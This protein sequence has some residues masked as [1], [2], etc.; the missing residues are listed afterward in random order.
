M[1][2]KEENE[3]VGLKLTILKTKIMTTAPFTSWQIDGV[4]VHGENLLGDLLL[5]ATCETQ[6]QGKEKGYINNGM[7]FHF[8]SF[9]RGECI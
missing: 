7:T 5:T 8:V 2:V 9:R 4:G 3:K 6:E 1:K